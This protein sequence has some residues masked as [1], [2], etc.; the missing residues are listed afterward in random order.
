MAVLEHCNIR[1]FDLA[2][3]VR[4]YEDVI[5]LRA[6]PVPGGNGRG[7]WLYDDNDIPV[8]HVIALDPDQREQGLAE[9][10]NRLGDLA[11]PLDLASM[12]GTGVI[13]HVAFRCEGYAAMVERLDARGLTYRAFDIPSYKL[14]Q[15]FVNDPSDV[16]LELNF[17]E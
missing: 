5:G 12:K 11:G 15:I 16:T 7:A 1:T 17:R 3:T 10:R 9:I 8:V 14:R 2:A 4:F 13:D 6:G